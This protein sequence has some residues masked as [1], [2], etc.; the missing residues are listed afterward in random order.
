MY[1]LIFY[2]MTSTNILNPRVKEIAF[3]VAIEDQRTY[4]GPNSIVTMSSEMPEV[5]HIAKPPVFSCPYLYLTAKTLEEAH[6]LCMRF[7]Y[8][9]SGNGQKMKNSRFAEY[10]GLHECGTLE[11]EYEK[12][13]GIKSA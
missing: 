5:I 13:I 11:L 9:I 8:T 12:A 10:R 4:G 1:K 6:Y 7:G 3:S 2:K